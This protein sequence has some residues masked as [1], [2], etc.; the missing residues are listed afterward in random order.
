MKNDFVGMVELVNYIRAWGKPN[1]YGARVPLVTQWNL[2][3]MEQ[4]AQSVSDREVV[5]FMRYGWSLNHDGREVSVSMFNHA[6]ATRYPQNMNEYIRNEHRLGCLFGPFVTL[7]WKDQVAVSPMS[8]RPKK[9]SRTKRRIIMDLSWPHNGKNVNAGISK[10]KYLEQTVNLQYPTV[11]RLCK[12]ITKMGSGVMGYKIDMDRAFKQLFMDPASWPLLGITWMN[13]LLFDKTAVMGS[14]SAP[15]MCQ[16]MTNF[17]RHIMCNI[18]HF[19]ANYVD[20][21]MGLGKPPK[22]W[23]GFITLQNLLRDLGASEALQ[24]TIEPTTQLEFLGVWFNM[25]DMTISVTKERMEELEMELEDWSKRE[26]YSRKQL[27]SLLGRLQFISNCV[28]PG[29][30][31]VFRL[32]NALRATGPGKHVITVEM[33]KDVMWWK[34]FLPT[35][36][37]VSIMWMQQTLVPILATDACLTGIGAICGNEYFHAELPVTLQQSG[38]LSIA[39]FELLAII[40]GLNKW[41]EKLKGTRSS[42][43]C[44]NLAVVHVINLGTARDIW[45]QKLMRWFAYVTATGQFEIVG[46]HICGRDNIGPDGLSRWH[47][48]KKYQQ[49]FEAIKGK[50]WVEIEIL[51]QDMIIQEIW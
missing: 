23:T 46:E 8:T 9:G 48:G 51:Q 15:Y 44:D 19:I 21:F 22:V 42:V 50:D 34:R 3:L 10:E 20:D 39:H 41:K 18:N 1:V 45:M 43:L 5:E 47:L 31:L 33:R 17:I 12:E 16:R 37:R 26:K 27:E 29:R 2:T 49:Q 24:K 11:D 36:S 30:I 35:Y 13:M 25:E 28:R 6:S 14:R 40:V 38:E 32:R 7:P 4:L